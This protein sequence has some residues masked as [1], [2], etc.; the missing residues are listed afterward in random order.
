MAQRYTDQELFAAI[1]GGGKACDQAI[2]YLYKKHLEK[3]CKFVTGRNGSREEAKDVFQDAIVNLLVG[4][5]EGKFEQKSS[6]GTYLYAISKNLWYRRFNRSL[7]QDNLESAG[8]SEEIEDG[9]PE[10]LLMEDHQREML[11]D[12]LSHLKPK[13]KEVLTLWSQRFSMKE[14]ASQLAYSNE[15]VVRNKKNHCLKELKEMVRKNPDVQ[16]LM[17]ELVEK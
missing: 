8:V 1:Q 10:I 9:T 6:L 15:Q 16:S 14:I 5:Q 17:A 4:I 3:I 11:G 12:L 13:C 7:K 2:Q